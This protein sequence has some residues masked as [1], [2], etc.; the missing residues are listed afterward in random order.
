MAGMVAPAAATLAD[1]GAPHRRATSLAADAQDT[2]YTGMSPD[3]P[4]A[5]QLAEARA[6]VARWARTRPGSGAGVSRTMALLAGSTARR[7]HHVRVLVYGQSISRDRWSATLEAALRSRFPHADL[8]FRNLAIGGF[9]SPMLVRTVVHDVIPFYPDLVILHDYGDEDDYEEIIRQIR[10][11]TTAEIAVQE[12]HLTIGQRD[13]WHDRHSFEWLHDLGKRW[14]LEVIEVRRAWGAFLAERKLERKAMLRDNA[15]LN[16]A[17]NALMVALTESALRVPAHKPHSS[18]PLGLVTTRHVG[19]DVA[20]VGDVLRVEFEGN[21]VD[22]LQAAGT[23]AADVRAAAEVRI[24]GKAPSEFPELYGFSR[25]NDSSNRDWPWEVGTIF[26][27]DAPAPLIPEEWRVRL[28]AVDGDPKR[29]RF[30]LFGSVTGFDGHGKSWEPFTSRSGRVAIAPGDWFLDL[31]SKRFGVKVRPGFEVRWH[32]E[33]RHADTYQDPAYVNPSM[34]AV[35]TVAQGLPPGAHV[36]ELRARGP[37][38]A[39]SAIKIYRPLPPEGVAGRATVG[40]GP[41]AKDG[42]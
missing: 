9:A 39:L 22:M 30:D 19:K 10:T 20:W 7:R 40:P 38:P 25:P 33:R 3:D 21:R 2:P 15:H 35:L 42:G 18:D 4:S 17:G 28:T 14:G 8:D 32:V 16:A 37:R 31:T 24:D 26:R 5:A 29:V 36:L 13:D 1:A 34:D 41:E 6:F 11:R 12:D 23:R 27:I